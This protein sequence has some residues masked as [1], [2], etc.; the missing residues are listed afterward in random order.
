M[1]VVSRKCDVEGQ[2]RR[3]PRSVVSAADPLAHAEMN[4]LRLAVSAN[5]QETQLAH[6]V[7]VSSAEPC[8][9]CTGAATT[10]GLC[11]LAIQRRSVGVACSH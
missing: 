5:L 10:P 3:P 4:V 11:L 1:R 8:S 6:C 7:V 2:G 9:M